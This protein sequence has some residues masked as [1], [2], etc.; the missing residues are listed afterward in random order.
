MMN[1]IKFL[2]E[3]KQEGAKVTWPSRKETVTTT[4]VVSVMIVV[5]TLVLLVTDFVIKH[6][7]QFILTLGTKGN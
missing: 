7:V 2:K 3:V 6:G 4:F 5:M 1:A